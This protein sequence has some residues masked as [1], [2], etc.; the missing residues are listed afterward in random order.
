MKAVQELM[1]KTKEY[2]YHLYNEFHSEEKQLILDELNRSC[3]TIENWNNEWTYRDGYFFL[4]S[5]Q[6]NAIYY[7]TGPS[8]YY[9]NVLVRQTD[10]HWESQ[11]P[12][13][14]YYEVADVIKD[15]ILLNTEKE[16]NE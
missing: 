10:D 13:M 16:T 5:N 12:I 4:E 7:L 1:M 6:D 14:D 9:F 2:F 8:P 3:S 15:F 11:H